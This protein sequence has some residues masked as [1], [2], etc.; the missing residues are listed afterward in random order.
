MDYALT[1]QRFFREDL[2]RDFGS[3]SQ[4]KIQNPK[5]KIVAAPAITLS[6]SLSRRHTTAGE[7]APTVSRAGHVNI[8]AVDDRFWNLTAHGP[9]VL[10]EGTSIVLNTQSAEALGAGVGDEVSLIVELPAAIPRD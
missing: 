6:G 2:S 8:Y 1:G 5:S 4:S 7:T 10:P 3:I 9:L